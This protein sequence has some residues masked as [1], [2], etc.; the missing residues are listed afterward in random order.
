MKDYIHKLVKWLLFL[1]VTL[2]FGFIISNKWIWKIPVRS[3][4]Y[5]YFTFLLAV[6]LLLKYYLYDK[7]IENKRGTIVNFILLIG[8]CAVFYLGLDKIYN[9][10]T[11]EGVTNWIYYETNSYMESF[12]NFLYLPYKLSGFSLNYYLSFNLLMDI[13]YLSL[14]LIYKNY[15]NKNKY[16]NYMLEIVL[17]KFRGNIFLII[18]GVLILAVPKL[19]KYPRI[20][21]DIF[22]T[23]LLIY[24]CYIIISLIV[25]YLS[26]KKKE[27]E[28]LS[29]KDLFIII[30]QNNAFKNQGFSHLSDFKGFINYRKNIV[31]KLFL[32]SKDFD[33]A[34]FTGIRWNLIDKSKYRNIYYLIILDG[35]R[36]RLMNKETLKELLKIIDN[37]NK[38][39]FKF[40]IVVKGRTSKISMELK[41]KYQFCYK[42]KLNVPYIFREVREDVQNIKLKSRAQEL[43]NK[44]SNKKQ[45][46][47][48][49]YSLNKIINSYNPIENFYTILKMA[50]YVLHYRALKNIALKEDL[51]NASDN[52]K[53]GLK[54]PTFGIWIS[55]QNGKEDKNK[56]YNDPEIIKAFNHIDDILKRPRKFEDK[57]VCYY[58]DICTY[59]LRLRNNILIHGVI[60]YDVSVELVED[61]FTLCENIV[62]AFLELNITI[63]DNELIEGL[64][65]NDSIKALE[66]EKNKYYLYSYGEEK[67]KNDLFLEYLNYD[68]GQVM[69][70]TFDN[71]IKIDERKLR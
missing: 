22:I 63:E 13:V 51:T 26:L 57:S 49:K 9:S 35:F 58:Q 14:I 16:I 66:E 4:L 12:H 32:E 41:R 36:L 28:D 52:L 39:G 40:K 70:K 54:A 7:I 31:N 25:T 33:I 29:N 64:F 17:K 62:L 30:N 2:L 48:L 50:E 56:K 18:W 11:G 65:K 5:L 53:E 38:E 45:Y 21:Q 59:L 55:Y 3:G 43:N 61:L 37:I 20:L 44:I 23:S 27:K 10:F 15:E 42:E 34:S 71:K 69:V 6:V 67:D 46:D 19:Y 1:G 68:N 8:I 60:T 47:Y 24:I